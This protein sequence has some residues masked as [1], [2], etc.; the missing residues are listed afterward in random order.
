MNLDP[1]SSVEGA[2]SERTRIHGS[3]CAS[4]HTTDTES[5]F[6]VS[7]AGRGMGSDSWG[8]PLRVMECSESPQTVHVT[9]VGLPVNEFHPTKLT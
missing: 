4:V 1:R 5:G 8:V 2:W 7:G 3:V 9:G 6:V